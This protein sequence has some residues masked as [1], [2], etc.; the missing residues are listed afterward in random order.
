MHKMLL[1]DDEPRQLRAMS[2]IIQSLRPHY[3]LFTAENGREALELMAQNDIKAVLT[4]IRMPIMDGMELINSL[5]NQGYRGKIVLITGFG[6]FAYAQQALRLGVFDYI[7]KPS[8]KRDLTKLLDALDKALEK[9]KQDD[10][11]RSELVQRLDDSRKAHEYQVLVDWVLGNKD[12]IALKEIVPS[13]ANDNGLLIHLKYSRKNDKAD[14]YRARRERFIAMLKSNVP[15]LKIVGEMDFAAEERAVVVAVYPNGNSS[16]HLKTIGCLERLTELI[17]T[18]DGVV[19]TVGC[20]MLNDHH[21]IDGQACYERSVRALERSFILGEGRV[22]LGDDTNEASKTFDVFEGEQSLT[23]AIHNHNVEQ[24]H[25]HLNALMQKIKDSPFPK[26]TV[27]KE[28][29]VRL[30]NGMLRELQH[31]L[32]KE[33]TAALTERFEV[34]IM[35]CDDYQELRQCLKSLAMDLSIAYRGALQDKNNLLIQ[36]CIAY[37]QTHYQEEL[38]L[39][40]M[41]GMF[42]FNSSYFSTLFKAYIGKSITDYVISV[43]IDKAEQLLA[44]SA[45][46]IADIAMKVGYKDVGYFIRVFRK[47]KGIT[48]KRYRHTAREER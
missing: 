17:K 37:I 10:E 35:S 26:P 24:I 7:V 11:S 36:K 18:N 46:K 15:E 8:G 32:P 43:R 2:A 3:E 38:S 48:P 5:S 20:V 1:V 4:D 19:W 29:F 21:W 47:V 13:D 23:N 44:G 31:V 27:I 45:D 30:M 14:S 25:S 39:E 22:I 34:K 6:D 40:T 16:V 28:D 9:E 33:E 41:A 12:G 42:H